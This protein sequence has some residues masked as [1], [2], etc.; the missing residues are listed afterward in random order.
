MSAN[1]VGLVGLY[2]VTTNYF[3][4]KTGIVLVFNCIGKTCIIYSHSYHE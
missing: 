1:D 2:G 3:L 4:C